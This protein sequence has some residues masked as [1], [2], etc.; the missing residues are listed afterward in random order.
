MTAV[1]AT[2]GILMSRVGGGWVGGPGML[3]AWH[4]ELATALVS[5]VILA[6]AIRRGAT[7]Y[8]YPAALGI[9]IALTHL[10]SWYVADQVGAGVALLVEGIVLLLGGLGAQRLRRQMVAREAG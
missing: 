6:L 9:V 5:L 1:V 7:A 10:N 3:E 8:L 2:A 4:A